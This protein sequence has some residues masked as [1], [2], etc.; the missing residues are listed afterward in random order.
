[1]RSAYKARFRFYHDSSTQRK[2]FWYFVPDDRETIPFEHAFYSRIYEREEL[3]QEEIGELYE[4]ISYY[5][6]QEP[7][8]STGKGLC[9]SETQWQ[10]GASIDDPRPPVHPGTKIPVCCLPPLLGCCGGL[11]YGRIGFGACHMETTC[12]IYSP[13]GAGSPAF[14][15]VPCQFVDDLFKGRG[16]SPINTVAW[17]H[18]IDVAESVSILDGCT[19]TATLNTL[20]YFDGDEVRIPSGGSARYVVVWVSLCDAEGTT[21]KRVYLMRH[22]V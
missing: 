8:P 12:D 19:R 6:G 5:G 7:C 13:F 18:Y 3:P 1:M 22:S 2:V 20:N 16:Q 4:P 11:A 10:A 17:T 9:G 14:S 15:N 21:V